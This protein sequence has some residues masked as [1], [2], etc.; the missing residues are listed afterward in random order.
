VIAAYAD[1][2]GLA[3]PFDGLV[4]GERPEPEP[5]PG[6]VVAT[7]EA[8]TANPHDLSTLRGVIGSPFEPPVILGCDGAGYGPDG[9]PVVFWPVLSP[10]RDGF[11]ML[12]DGVD[13]TF[14]PRIALPAESLV[15]KPGNLSF[16][17]AAGLGVAWLTAWRMLFTKAKVRRGERV[18]VQGASGGVATAAII[19]ARAAGAA[20]TV[21]SRREE[22]R[23]QALRLGASCALPSGARL[24]ERV[25]VAL[26]TVGEAT[27]A[28]TLRSL[29]P[30]GRIVVAGAISGSDP[31]AGLLR[32]AIRE[33]TVMG[34]MMG[35]RQEFADLCR[36]V[37]DH[38]L[39]PPLSAVFDG[40]EQ[41]P[42]ALRALD[43]GRALGKLVVRIRTRPS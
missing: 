28:H 16:E 39:H 17:E 35:T 43:A 24:P 2:L 4:V 6:W 14:A 25:D 9:T 13:G 31:P 27:W 37:E 42:D 40:V 33:F 36:F 38:D 30:E 26:E 29:Q 3:D 18:L 8:A 12:T 7:V 10:P 19:L 34:S 41:V 22:A 11:R 5:P 15:E 21:T 1:K 20:V 32:V 23:A